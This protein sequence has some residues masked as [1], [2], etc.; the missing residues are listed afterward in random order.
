LVATICRK[1]ATLSTAGSIRRSGWLQQFYNATSM[2]LLRF[3]ILRPLLIAT[4]LLTL[5]APAPPLPAAQTHPS[6]SAATNAAALVEQARAAQRRDEEDS[7]RRAEQALT[8]LVAAPDPDQEFLAR[9]VLCEYYTERDPQATAEQIAAL[10]ALASQTQR[11]GLRAGLFV[12]RGESRQLLG[13]TAMAMIDYDQAVSS[14]TSANDEE[15]LARA[16]F[17]RGFLRG[18]QGEYADS[19]TDLRRAESLYTK[20]AKPLETQTVLDGIA[21]MYSRMGDTEQAR[22]IYE[23]SLQILRAEGLVREQVIVEHNIGRAS[24]RLGD[25]PTARRAFDSALRLSRN[26]GY[27]RGEAYALRGIAAVEVGVG[28]T[29]QALNDLQRARQLGIA[30]HDANLGAMISL[31]EGMAM[32]ASGDLVRARVLLNQALE[33]FRQTNQRNEMLTTYEQLALVDSEQGDWRR[34]FQW[35]QAAKSTA[36]QL[37]R[38]QIDQRFAVLKMEFDTA[39][40]EKEYQALLRESSANERALSQADR[41][42]RLQYAVLAL[43]VLIAAMLAMLAW[44]LHRSSQRLRQL[45]LTDELTGVPNRRAVLTQLPSVLQDSNGRTAA[46]LLLDIDHFKRINDKFGH[47]AGDRVLQLVA[48][49]IRNSL[50]PGEFFGRVGGEEFLVVLPAATLRSAHLHAENLRTRIGIIDISGVAPDL[51]PLSASIGVAISRPEDSVRTILQRADAALYCAKAA[52][53]NLVHTEGLHEA[54]PTLLAH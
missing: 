29:R 10:E 31:T 7:R 37:L 42:R 32:R 35:Q 13:Q 1:N 12:C 22:Q 28:Q 52:G 25:W 9:L 20:L 19:L 3:H 21:S 45:A 46:A 39:T 48:A 5:L 2:A 15:M 18:L 36:E 38:I 11:K 51:P 43:I 50:L 8:L 16:L 4:A 40:R 26:L 53:R 24:E 41:A 30:S 54:M 6:A 14:A 23:K 17:S 27:V 33:A 34:A 44:Q 49:Q 47:P